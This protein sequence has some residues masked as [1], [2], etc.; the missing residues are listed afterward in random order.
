MQAASQSPGGTGGTGN[1]GGGVLAKVI[2]LI[3][4]PIR[5]M[6]V[7]PYNTHMGEQ[8]PADLH[9]VHR[10]HELCRIHPGR[11]DRARV[12]ELSRDPL[13]GRHGCL[14]T[15]HPEQGPV[16]GLRQDDDHG[17]RRRPRRVRSLAW[18]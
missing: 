3:G 1:F 15:H 7:L 5:A 2:G 17:L 6:H 16:Q 8:P 14:K 12:D 10:H 11:H 18:I 4:A 9:A 13:Q